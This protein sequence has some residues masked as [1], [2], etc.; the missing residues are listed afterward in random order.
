MK[1]AAQQPAKWTD[2]GDDDLVSDV[3][4]AQLLSV[5]VHTLRAWRVARPTQ[6]GPR[7]SRLGAAVRY[8]VSDLRTFVDRAAVITADDPA[9]AEGPTPAPVTLRRAG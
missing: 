6:R 8:R 1:G 2:V 5:S 3:A 7:F 4:A 9:P